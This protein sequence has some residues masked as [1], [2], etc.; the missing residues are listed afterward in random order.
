[1]TYVGIEDRLTEPLRKKCKHVKRANL[2]YYIANINLECWVPYKARW[3]ID[4][5]QPYLITNMN[6]NSQSLNTQAHKLGIQVVVWNYI[7]QI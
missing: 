1:M 4:R 3:P 6:I 5:I 2:E 7:K